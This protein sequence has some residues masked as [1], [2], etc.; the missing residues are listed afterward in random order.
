RMAGTHMAGLLTWRIAVAVSLAAFVARTEASIISNTDDSA[1]RRSHLLEEVIVTAQ[2]LSLLT[3]MRDDTSQLLSVAGAAMDPL[4]AVMALPGVTF[5]SDI[6]S[7]PAVR[8]SAP[9]D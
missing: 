1:E 6:S 8:G 7:E 9:E 3:E 5:T 4:N 2:S